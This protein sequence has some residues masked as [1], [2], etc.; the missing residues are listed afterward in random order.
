MEEPKIFLAVT[1]S[2]GTLGEIDG[3]GYLCGVW[4][5][6]NQSIENLKLVISDLL[7]EWKSNDL[8][9]WIIAESNFGLPLNNR[10]EL[11]DLQAA[12]QLAS[13]RES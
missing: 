12:I 13:K 1:S 7:K 11:H 9:D 3:Q 2:W 6:A 10:Q 5:K 8:N 4:I